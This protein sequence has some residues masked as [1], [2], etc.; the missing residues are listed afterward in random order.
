MH[1]TFSYHCF[2]RKYS[3]EKHSAGEPIIDPIGQRPRM[4]CPIRYR[5]PKQLPT[6]ILGLIH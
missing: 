6:L 1:V 2:S 3:A 5:L 4:F